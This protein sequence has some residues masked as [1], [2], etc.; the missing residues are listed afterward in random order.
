MA[1]NAQRL[2]AR[3]FT[4]FRRPQVY[5]AFLAVAAQLRLDTLAV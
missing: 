5:S 4:T 1:E 2:T 3:V